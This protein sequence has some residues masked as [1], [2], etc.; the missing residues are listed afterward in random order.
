MHFFSFPF[1]F[2]IRVAGAE[3]IGLWEAFREGLV[4]TNSDLG[5]C[6]IHSLHFVC[7]TVLR[8][9]LIYSYSKV[10]VSANEC[11]ENMCPQLL[12]LKPTLQVYPTMSCLLSSRLSQQ[13]PLL[14]RLLLLVRSRPRHIGDPKNRNTFPFTPVDTTAYRRRTPSK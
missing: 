14:F 1:D 10:C 4:T 3:Y 7:S 11:T 8:N 12:Q 13:N 2:D 9:F 5:R 6:A